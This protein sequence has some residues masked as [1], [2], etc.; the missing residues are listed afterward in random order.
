MKVRE[1]N[2]RAGVERYVNEEFMSRLDGWK[3]VA[4]GAAM[5]MLLP[6]IKGEYDVDPI[7]NALKEQFRKHPE[8]ITINRE[9]MI[10]MHPVYGAVVAAIVAPVTFRTDDLDR[11][12]NFIINS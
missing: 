12:Y 7:Y 2:I 6:Q 3:Q 1:Q 10:Q 8:G 9:D 4:M 5:G 11:L